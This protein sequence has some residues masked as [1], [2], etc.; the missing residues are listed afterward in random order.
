M[1]NI[2]IEIKVGLSVLIAIAIL[3]FGVIWIKDFKFN[4]ERYSY[5]VL[6]PNIGT[7]EVGDPVSVL[8]VRKGEVRKIGISGNHVLVTFTLT[9]DIVLREDA[10]FTVMNIGLMGERFINISLGSSGSPLDLK[11]PVHGYYDTGI[12]EVM[13][14]AGGAMEELRHLIAILEGSLGTPAATESIRKIITNLDKISSDW[15]QFTEQNKTKMGDAVENLSGA[16]SKLND[17]IYNNADKIDSAMENVNRGSRKFL[18]LTVKLDSLSDSAH[19]L[20]TD[21]NNG[22]GTLG[23]ALKDDSLYSQ[24]LI[25]TGNLDSLIA[26]FK[27]N[28]RRYVKLSIF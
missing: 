20:I 8:G 18:E 17:L 4:I 13:G 6:F 21:L 12:P 10:R 25:T 14:M 19:S 2:A 3:L 9:K 26:D 5:S 1:R 11:T 7:L 15:Q 24:L 28:P 27:R 23:R 16:S 22:K